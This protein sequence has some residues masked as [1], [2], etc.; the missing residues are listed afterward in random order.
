MEVVALA[1]TAIAADSLDSDAWF[2]LADAWQRANR[3]DSAVVAFESLLERWPESVE[4]VV[5][6]GLA[7]EEARRFEDA[8]A[9]YRRAIELDPKDPTPRVNLGSLL[10][11]NFKR[12]FEA[13]EALSAALE[14]DPDHS[15]AHFNLGVLFADARMFKE[16]KRE[17]EFVLDK[18]PD[19]PAGALARENLERISPL[20]Q[21]ADAPTE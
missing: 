13:K 3:P 19:S 8:L 7:L 16:A 2:R 21:E 10:Y 9:Q 18:T 4:A 14:L 17:W 5:H 1:H 15:D 12:T 20:F 6:Y 11:F